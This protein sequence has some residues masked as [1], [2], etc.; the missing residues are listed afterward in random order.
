MEI[1]PA[2][3]DA[4]Q[5]HRVLTSLVAPRPIGWISS[6]SADGTENLAPFSYFNGVST[7]P[8]LVVFGPIDKADDELKDTP[9]NILETGEFICNLVT[10]KHL[11]AMDR[12]SKEVDPTVDEFESAG[13]EKAPGETVDVSRVADAPAVMECTLF[14]TVDLP[15]STA[16]FGRVKHF[17][18]DE[19]LCIDGDIDARKVDAIGRIGGPYYTSITPLDFQRGDG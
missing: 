15:A 5:I 2:A 1:D 11:A 4:D 17:F 9:R 10:E 8:P 18:V 19:E 3:T 12:S 14:E 16:I 13:L 7:K 6:K